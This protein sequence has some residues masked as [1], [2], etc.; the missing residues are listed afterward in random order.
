[1]SGLFFT[2]RRDALSFSPATFVLPEVPL[3]RVRGG[4][5]RPGYLQRGWDKGAPVRE[6]STRFKRRRLT[7]SR[8]PCPSISPE[9][10][11][12]VVLRQRS[13]IR[14]QMKILTT[15][16]NAVRIGE[17]LAI[18]RSLLP[19]VFPLFSLFN[20]NDYRFTRA[21][22]EKH[23]DNKWFFPTQ[24]YSHSIENYFDYSSIHKQLDRVT[25][26]ALAQF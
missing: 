26:F 22:D 9:W 17:R 10:W 13:A 14:S 1:M 15:I 19:R 24:I 12:R 16:V 6:S 3:R 18:D 2:L 25:I 4:Q 23:L 11:R 8:T 7:P 20:F 21:P 5:R